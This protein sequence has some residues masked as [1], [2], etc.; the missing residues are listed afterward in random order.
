ME[1]CKMMLK[2]HNILVHPAVRFL[3]FFFPSD[4]ATVK[5]RRRDPASAFKILLHKQ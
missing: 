1:S 2:M 3:F 5:Y 4:L